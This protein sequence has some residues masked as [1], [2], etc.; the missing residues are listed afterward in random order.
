MPDPVEMHKVVYH[1]YRAV[2]PFLTIESVIAAMS[3]LNR[4]SGVIKA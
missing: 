1:N 4:K 2:Q 3:T